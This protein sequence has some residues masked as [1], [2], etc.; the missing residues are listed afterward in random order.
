MNLPRKDLIATAAV[1]V[2]AVLYL[3]WAADLTLPG[4]GDARAT[5]AS[6]LVLGFVASAFAVV[7]GFDGLL[8]GNR[9][10]L[11]ATVTLGA[12]AL[13]AGVVAL[14]TSEG[15]ALAG[16]VGATVALWAIS[17][18]HHVLLAREAQAPPRVETRETVGAHSR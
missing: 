2:A 10:Y 9:A 5:A 17:T 8:H 11:A 7:P 6:I 15:L 3:L 4:M 12:A 1:A 16:L 13:A 14:V 18:T